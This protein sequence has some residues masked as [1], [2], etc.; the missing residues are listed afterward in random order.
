MKHRHL[1]RSAGAIL[2]TGALILSLLPITLAAGSSPAVSSNVNKED[3]IAW[4]SPVTSYLYE[5]SSGGL[6]RVEYTN[7]Q[8][9]VENYTSSFAFVDSRIIQPELPVWGGFFAGETY[10]FLIFGQNNPAES[11]STEVIRVVKYDKNWKR[12]GAASLKGANTVIPFDAGSLRCDEYGGY[13]YIRTCHE[14]YTSD[15]GLN[16]QA[17]LTFRHQVAKVVIHII[18][19]DFTQ[20]EKDKF[21]GVS[22]IDYPLSGTWSIIALDLL[23]LNWVHSES[24]KGDIIP[25]NLGPQ[26]I[27][28]NG[29]EIT[30]FT[31]YEALVLPGEVIYNKKIF[32]FSFDGYAPFYY[33]HSNDLISWGYGDVY[34]YCIEINSTGAVTVGSVT[35]GNWGDGGSYDLS[36]Q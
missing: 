24:D 2:C 6:T 29:K 23:D 21:K 19:N 25:Y 30:T 28:R 8:V 14:M 17:N 26:K 36:T 18:D 15:D 35:Q 11:D 7:S 16:H 32:K 12:L 4:S 20:A 27:T 33:T 22:I 5:N 10:N 34:T 31:S 9:V 1:L 13:L 3:Y